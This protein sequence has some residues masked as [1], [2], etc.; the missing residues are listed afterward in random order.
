VRCLLFC[1]GFCAATTFA[2]CG[3]SRVSRPDVAA[4]QPRMV[5]STHDFRELSE[6]V[7]EALAPPAAF[8][9]L[10]RAVFDPLLRSLRIRPLPR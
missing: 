5:R 2:A 7:V 10:A 6:V 4:P 9:G 1:L 8:G 3:N